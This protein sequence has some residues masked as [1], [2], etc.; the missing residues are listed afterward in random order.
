MF[1]HSFLDIRK[2][3][4]QDGHA[5]LRIDVINVPLEKGYSVNQQHHA[6]HCLPQ[7]VVEH[8]L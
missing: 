8:V 3:L 4:I 1:F 6:G 5:L 7:S 2:D